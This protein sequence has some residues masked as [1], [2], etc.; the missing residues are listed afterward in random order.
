[1]RDAS[2]QV[3]TGKNI[4]TDWTTFQP[5][6]LLFFGNK[7]T[8]RITHV[9]IH[10]NNGDYVHSSGRVKRNSLNPES[11]L[12]GSHSFITAVRIK[13]SIPSEGITRVENHPWFFDKK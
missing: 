5:G 3:K 1:M 4:G 11:P 10:D 7:E 13:G 2:Q 9:A 12:Y 6:D 8:G